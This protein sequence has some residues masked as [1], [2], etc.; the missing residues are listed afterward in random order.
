MK[1]ILCLVLVGIMLL[2]VVTGCK[3]TTDDPAQTAE[4]TAT[5]T[6]AATL[7]ATTAVTTETTT[8]TT[9]A[10]T[11]AAT[12]E[13]PP[14]LQGGS[15]SDFEYKENSSGGITIEKYIGNDTDVVIPQTI[16][17]KPVTMIGGWCFSRKFDLRSVTIPDSVTII[18]SCAFSQCT[19]LETVK[20]PSNLEHF[21]GAVF[22]G[23]GI[24]EITLPSSL[25]G[26]G[27]RTFAD[28]KNLKEVFIPKGVMFNEEVFAYAGLEKITFEEGVE[29]IADAMF[30]GTP[31]KEVVLPQSIKTIGQSAFADCANLE[32]IVLNEGLI[33]I[34]T[35]AFGGTS[36]LKEI[37]IPKT[38]VNMKDHA[39]Y[40]CETLETVKFEGNA[41][42]DY[43]SGL[44]DMPNYTVYYHGGA[45][46]FTSPEWCGYPTK[47]W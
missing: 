39:F 43:I 22:E 27:Y 45:E 35:Y 34:D 31:I 32:S 24:T 20:L 36:K 12:T 25:I 9:T 28:C 3:D 7:E 26:G 14:T 23:S 29:V 10:A 4:T 17:G 5:A 11:T 41:P 30:F 44:P 42:A 46:G 21:G 47:L 40:S 16:N 2:T 1:K 18:S 15:T 19:G 6:T 37:V 33:T 38:V 8:A 13:A